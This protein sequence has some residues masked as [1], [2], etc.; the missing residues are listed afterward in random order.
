V[1]HVLHVSGIVPSEIFLSFDL[2]YD[3]SGPE[4]IIQACESHV[5]G[6]LNRFVSGVVTLQSIT[7]AADAVFNFS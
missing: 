2:C 3:G 7:R 1:L 5:L 4:L 6:S